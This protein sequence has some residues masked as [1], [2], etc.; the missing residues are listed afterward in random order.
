[1]SNKSVKK[2][3][4][5][6]LVYQVVTIVVPI[7]TTPY[8]TRVIYADG[9]GHISYIESIVSYF[10]LFAAFGIATFAQREISYNHNS[11]KDCSIIFW[12]NII[13][14]IITTSIALIAYIPLIIVLNDLMYLVFLV[15]IVNVIFDISWFFQGLEEFRG[16]CI[17]STIIKILQTVLTFVLIKN[18]DDIYIY[19]WVLCGCTLLR[20]LS[21]WPSIAKRIVKVNINELHPLRNFKT[22]FLLFM[23]SIAVQLYTVLDKTMIGFITQ[24]DFQ[25]GYYELALRIVKLS[26]T[27]ITVVGTVM[28]P[29]I[30]SCIS[31]GNI[32][33]AKEYLYKS[34]RFVWLLGIPMCLGLCFVSDNFVPWYFGDG[35]ESVSTLIKVLSPLTIIIGCSNVSAV[36]FLIPIK[37]EK[38]FTIVAFS[39]AAIN[40]I[41]NV[42][43][44]YYFSALG[45]AIATLIAESFITIVLF[46]Y[47]RKYLSLF[48]IFKSIIKYLVS[49]LIMSIVL[50]FE[51]I[52]LS[53]SVL[54]T[55][56]IIVSGACSYFIVLLLLRDSFLVDN[57]KN[58]IGKFRR[59]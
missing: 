43:L 55:F 12:E 31:D 39:A 16:I 53:S 20:S 1:M 9:I 32:D 59:I 19:C 37:K 36:Q 13:R 46:V 22:I 11:I 15:T 26:T 21:F 40:V 23:P 8:L 48:I 4:F 45:A 29:R 5:Y 28:A 17:R 7:I 30:S 24:D 14:S 27:I 49:G 58:I 57:I 3:Y 33:V 25:N 56:I 52:Y 34:Y 6:N 10:S 50:V 51:N 38:V 44:I 47:L 42:I 2:N 18:V 41:A 35:Y 54:N